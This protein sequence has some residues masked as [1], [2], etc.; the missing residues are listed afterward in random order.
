LAGGELSSEAQT[1]AEVRRKSRHIFQLDGLRGLAALAVVVAHF[2]PYGVL[3]SHPQPGSWVALLLGIAGRFSVGN[4]AVATFFGLSAFLLTYRARD[5]FKRSAG[6]SPRQFII[7]RCLRIWPLYFFVVVAVAAIVFL[8]HSAIGLQIVGADQ[9]TRYWLGPHLW[10]YFTFLSNWSLTFSH[11]YGYVDQSPNPFRLLWSIAVEEQFYLVYPLLILVTLRSRTAR[12]IVPIAAVA[13]AWIFRIW[14]IHI[15]MENGISVNGGL[16]YATLSYGES[17]VAGAV[18]GWIYAEC[19]SAFIS[20]LTR[21]WVGLALLFAVL[22]VGRLWSGKLW[23]PYDTISVVMYSVVAVLFALVLLWLAANPSGVIGRVLGSRLFC[24]FGALSY[25]VYVWHVISNAVLAR[26]ISKV[27][28][29]GD[30]SS[31]LW[32]FSG[33]VFSLLFAISFA[34]FTYFL[35]EKRFLKIKD[36]IGFR[37]EARP[38]IRPVKVGNIPSMTAV[39][40]ALVISLAGFI[41]EWSPSSFPY[42]W[43]TTKAEGFYNELSDSLIAGQLS[44]K[45]QPDVRLASLVDPYDPAAN[46]AYRVND[47]S[48]YRGKYYLYMGVAP[49]VTLFIPFNILTGAFLTEEAATWIYCTVGVAACCMLLFLV[50]RR[51]TR[52]SPVILLIGGFIAVTLGN[53]FYGVIQGS[54]AQHVTI[55]AGF[56]F[57]MLSL[58]FLAFTYLPERSPCLWFSLASI[59]YGCAI[60]SRPNYLFGGL[61]LLPPLVSALRDKSAPSWSKLLAASLLPVSAIVGLVLLYNWARFG[62]PFEFGQRYQLGGWNQLHLAY[63]G[64]GQVAENVHNFLFGGALVSPFFPFVTPKTWIATGVLRYVPLLWLSPVAIWALFRKGPSPIARGVAGSALILG[65]LTFCTL[66]LLPSGNPAAVV[67]SANGRYIIDFLPALILFVSVGTMIAGEF[68]GSWKPLGRRALV[69]A[70]SVLAVASAIVGLSLDFARF[71]TDSYRPLARVLNWPSYVT[72]SWMGERYGPIGLTLKLPSGKT[73]AYEPLLSA[74]TDAAGDLLLLHYEGNASISLAFVSTGFVGPVS[75]P[76]VLDFA[77]P[78]E[79]EISMGALFP[80]DGHPALDGLDD[81]QIAYLRR[82]VSVSIDGSPVFAAIVAHH[83]SLPG[84]VLVG[85]NLILTNYSSHRFTGLVEN[86]SR[87]PIVPPAGVEMPRTQFG[88][89]RISLLLASNPTFGIREPLLVTGVNQAGDFITVEYSRDGRVRFALDHWG[90]EG[91]QS[92]WLPVDRH[93]SHSI[94]ISMGSLYPHSGDG[95]S[96]PVS[97]EHFRKLKDTV[98]VSFDDKTI[99]EVERPTYDSSPFDVAVG[100]NVIGGSTCVYS[101]SGKVTQVD[102]LGIP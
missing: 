34:A 22:V 77:K 47:L 21:R 89:V 83:N 94:V 70:A 37:R 11:V 100:H 51:G 46:Q 74:G 7:R 66:I 54:I 90:G 65:T 42:A 33:L 75:P 86:E 29:F 36:K 88:P 3:G 50:R 81:A 31:N 38:S 45:R 99:L 73:G 84:Q 28:A 44:F 35:I 64:F 93:A 80:P 97:V 98:K 67:T 15:P 62:R 18:A 78:H 23:Y 32:V 69:S 71:P 76:F 53:G 13:G 6:F 2:N 8:S 79:F 56:A 20:V 57:A 72:M 58:L 12:W 9:D 92:D 26:L 91:A 40:L 96:I 60:A 19:D 14:F 55:A 48:Y 27:G 43:A 30:H 5:E 41:Y 24:A 102:R 59:A 49:A 39:G 10:L 63:S 4:L 101:F 82:H 95:L 1:K 17:F 52:H 16:Y 87:L 85:Q 68:S 25:G 61:M